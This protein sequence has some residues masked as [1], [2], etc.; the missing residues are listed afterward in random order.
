MIS[1]EA[2][3]RETRGGNAHADAGF[4][5]EKQLARVTFLGVQLE[6]GLFESDF[7]ESNLSRFRS[8][9]FL[10]KKIEK[11]KKIRLPAYP[12]R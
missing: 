2:E 8:K 1:R 12:S 11:T 6:S 5:S 4:R 10:K 3:R 9:G 7:N